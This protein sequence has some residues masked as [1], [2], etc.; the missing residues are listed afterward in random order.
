MSLHR[1]LIQFNQDY[2][3]FLFH[4]FPV[5][6]INFYV[7][8]EPGNRVL[9]VEE[10]EPSQYLEVTVQGTTFSPLSFSVLYLDYEEFAGFAPQ[11]D[12]DSIFQTR[13]VSANCEFIYSC[14]SCKLVNTQQIHTKLRILYITV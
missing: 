4:M 10:S 5:I 1:C 9:E 6:Y 7:R 13:P 14:C 8:G 3:F 2:C 11:R 12:L